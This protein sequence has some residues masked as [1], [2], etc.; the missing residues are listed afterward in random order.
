[1]IF[2]HAGPDLPQDEERLPVRH[3]RLLEAT[4]PRFHV[5]QKQQ[6]RGQ[7]FL[8]GYGEVAL[9]GNGHFHLPYR[10]LAELA[11]STFREEVSTEEQRVRDAG[12]GGV[13]RDHDRYGFG[14]HRVVRMLSLLRTSAIHHGLGRCLEAFH[15]AQ[16]AAP[17]TGHKSASQIQSSH[18]V[19]PIT[20]T[21]SNQARMGAIGIICCFHFLGVCNSLRRGYRSRCSSI[22]ALIS[23]K[24]FL[25]ER[26]T[27]RG[28]IQC[29]RIPP[30]AVTSFGHLKEGESWKGGLLKN[31]FVSELNNSRAVGLA[32]IGFDSVLGNCRSGCFSFWLSK[33]LQELV[34]RSCRSN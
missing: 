34:T 33:L 9:D 14:E 6:G 32:G 11:Q 2:L 28:Y 23:S 27:L 12:M 29:L 18:S 5:C 24:T 30:E 7:L 16:N 20:R 31:L 4:Q 21:S 1:M 25:L 17:D 22:A 8:V 19:I 13:L 26:Q 10:V 3:V 15:N